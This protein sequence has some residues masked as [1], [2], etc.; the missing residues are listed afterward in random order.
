M[1]DKLIFNN[2][3]EIRKSLIHGWG[4]FA[5]ENIKSGEILEEAPFLIVPMSQGEGSSLFIDYR[6]N[7]PRTGWKY[8]TIPFGF[9]CIY[10]HSNDPNAG[11]ETDNENNLFVFFTKRDIMKDEEICTYYGSENYWQDG[12]THTKV[13]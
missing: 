6:F 9:S 11:W 4:V 13:I 10:N 3:I 7:F 5:K 2:K 8:Q 12:R 1:K